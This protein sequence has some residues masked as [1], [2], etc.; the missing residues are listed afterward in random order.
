M[1]NPFKTKYEIRR[2]SEKGYHTYVVRKY[3][4]QRKWHLFGMYRCW[5]EALGAIALVRGE[6][7]SYDP[8]Y[9][10]TTDKSQDNENNP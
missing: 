3:W 5:L 6:I 7:T 4:W 8:S 10:P 1:N 9:E 2:C